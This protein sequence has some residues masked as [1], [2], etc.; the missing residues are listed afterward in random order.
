M[1]AAGP[2]ALKL[3]LLATNLNFSWWNGSIEAS[4]LFAS[5]LTTGLAAGIRADASSFTVASVT[6]YSG[7][8]S[9]TFV[10]LN[11]TVSA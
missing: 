3:D 6:P 10:S 7:S 9:F 5:Q 4:S 2:G 11:I 8:E 1:R